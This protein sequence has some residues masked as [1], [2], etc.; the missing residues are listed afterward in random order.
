[1]RVRP[2][3]LILG[4]F[5]AA[6]ATATFVLRQLPREG[7]VSPLPGFAE[8]PA[9][10]GTTPPLEADVAPHGELELR[11]T[12]GGEP[13]AGAEVRAYL[14]LEPG[15]G[16]AAPEWRRAGTARSDPGGIA[17]LPA[18]DGI[19]LVAVRSPGL[20][21]ARRL[22]VR[23]A[24]EATAR[25]DVA[26]EPPAALAGAVLDPGGAPLPGIRVLVLPALDE[27]GVPAS[28]PPEE[29]AVAITAADGTFA[30]AGIAPGLHAVAAE[31]E[32]RHP[33]R[34]PRVAVPRDGPLAMVLEP[35]GALAGTVAQDGRPAAGAEVLAASRDH[36]ART[37]AGPD[38]RF[39]LRLPAGAYRV[40]ATAGD[41]AAAAGPLAVAAGAETDAQLS[42]VRASAIEGTVVEAGS[43]RPVPGAELVVA[44]HETGTPVAR[45]S[46]GP[47]G[48]FR[49]DGLAPG[50]HDLAASAPGRSP[51]RAPALTLPDGAPFRLRLPLEAAGAVLG[52]V[53]DGSG[54]A[55][56]GARIRIVTEGDGLLPARRRDA[57]TDF[58]GRFRVDGIAAGR[59]ELSVRQDGV[60]AGVARR[61]RVSP[62]GAAE[63]SVVLPE[64]GLV[65]GRVALGVRRPP[66][67]TAVI[68]LPAR[69]A[70]SA[71]EIGRTLADAAGHYQLALPEGDYRVLAAPAEEGAAEARAEAARA[72]V[73]AG[74]TA[75]LDLAL[76]PPAAGGI[77]VLVVE[78]GGAPSPGAEVTLSRPGEGSAAFAAAAGED[79]RLA[80]PAGASLAGREA[81][82]HA[83]NGGRV[84]TWEG[85]LP[86]GGTVTVR[87]AA[88]GAVAGRVRGDGPAISG[89][90]LEVASRPAAGA[91]RTADVHRF[92]GDRFTLGDLPAEPVRIV[93][94]AED[95]RR[96]EAEVTLAAGE[97]RPLEIAV[98]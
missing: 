10:E 89:F 5:G 25:A 28:A 17:R 80:L 91:W 65:A 74:R 48:R 27:P 98:R 81:A 37:V 6:A 40:A 54:R 88:A 94:R 67:G 9:L 83:R 62:G 34:L 95:G 11:V 58:E 31:G 87:L 52:R 68:A 43:G 23:A 16:R 2:A 45:A 72:R 8:P 47:D 55:I 70:S 7:E 21:P 50:A 76:A 36:A 66:A 38:G 84:G 24:E 41:R 4:I 71:A 18:R 69:G 73:E 13:L 12:A 56:A 93:V 77:A 15:A 46:A 63:V 29:T 33:A 96:G 78:P 51:A 20:A 42:L 26:L 82:V 59:A 3:L 30:V 39:A 14:A 92:S 32:G 35:L 79:G 19:H 75:R 1:M 97:T 90:T 61:V 44:L 53:T 85:T 57:R 22:V 64:A 86:G 60:L 49:I